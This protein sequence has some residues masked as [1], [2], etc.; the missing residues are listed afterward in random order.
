M[1][2]DDARQIQPDMTP[3]A[4][5]ILIGTITVVLFDAVA[6]TASRQLGFKYALA[7]FGVLPHLCR[8]G[9]VRRTGWWIRKCRRGGSFDGT[10]RR[11]D[12]VGD[13]M[14]N[15]PRSHAGWN[16]AAAP[17]DCGGSSCHVDGINLRR[18]RRLRG[19]LYRFGTGD[20]TTA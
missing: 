12:W 5:I 1:D 6:A 20:D 16:A 18:C 4:K 3:S 9:I 8:G 15:R 11:D 17:M 2:R 10:H 19:T 14:G 7:A 13:L